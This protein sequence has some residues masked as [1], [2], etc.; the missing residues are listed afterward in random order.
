MVPYATYR[1]PIQI[2][3]PFTNLIRQYQRKWRGTFLGNERKGRTL[4]SIS[5]ASAATEESTVRSRR[6]S[7]VYLV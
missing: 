6:E 1:V 2:A 5:T 4:S 3:T 7:Q